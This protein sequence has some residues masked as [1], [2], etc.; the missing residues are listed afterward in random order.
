MKLADCITDYLN[1]IRYERGLS[2]I[3]CLHYQC[4]LRHFSDWLAENGYPDPNLEDVFT[5]PV[6]RRYQRH[7]AKDG[8]RPR[9]VPKQPHV[10]GSYFVRIAAHAISTSELGLAT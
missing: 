9:T 2:K 7:K 5:L 6:L 10:V 1:H 4:W 3:T 8:A